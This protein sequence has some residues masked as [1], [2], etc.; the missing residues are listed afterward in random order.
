MSKSPGAKARF[1]TLFVFLEYTELTPST[2]FPLSDDKIYTQKLHA[3][4]AQP[5]ARTRMRANRWKFSRTQFA[6]SWTFRGYRLSNETPDTLRY[7]A[8]STALCY[9]QF[10]LAPC[11][12]TRLR[13]G[14]ASREASRFGKLN[15]LERSLRSSFKTKIAGSFWFSLGMVRKD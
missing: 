8:Y 3:K 12:P 9:R 14:D 11:K 15:S 5:R 13:S 2:I 6:S 7:T 10:G 1:T 4:S